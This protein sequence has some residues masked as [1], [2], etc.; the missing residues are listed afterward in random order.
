[1]YGLR[2]SG[3]IDTVAMQTFGDKPLA[4]SDRSGKALAA[5][6]RRR[7]APH[8]AEAGGAPGRPPPSGWD[9]AAA[10]PKGKPGPRGTPGRA[11]RSGG[12]TARLPHIKG[13]APAGPAPERRLAAVK[14]LC[15]EP[16]TATAATLPLFSPG[17]GDETP[18]QPHPFPRPADRKLISKC[19]VARARAFPLRQQG[20][21][22][23]KPPCSVGGQ[24]AGA[25]TAQRC[26]YWDRVERVMPDLWVERT[27]TGTASGPAGKCRH[28][29]PVQSSPES[30]PDDKPGP[31]SQ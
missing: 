7:R 19:L 10:K 20:E 12:E 22:K 16:L 2:R 3:T 11:R 6:W 4:T 13:P 23:S 8:R 30:P 31:R 15:L 28:F 27:G 1:M 29:Q 18:A 14:D 21:Q 25:V 26:H 17:P 5:G 24:S 9:Q